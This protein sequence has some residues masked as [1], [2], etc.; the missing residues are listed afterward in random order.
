MASNPFSDP[1]AVASY[2]ERAHRMVPG[3]GVLHGI[4]DQVLAESVPQDGRIL[5]VGAGG[6]LELKHFAQHHDGWTFDGVD[7]SEPMLALA[8]V[9]MG[10][11][12][13]RASLHEGDVTI[14]PDGPFDAATC[15][16]TL[17]FLDQAERL[18]TLCAI[19]R[20]L[21][22][23]APFLTFHHS[24]PLDGAR[25]TRFER[26]ARFSAGPDTPPE[27]VSRT[28]A[29]LASQLP[30]VGPEADEG[31]L[32]EAGFRSVEVYYSALTLRGWLAYA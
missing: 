16:L 13:S 26:F 3:L 7:P 15:L 25:R 19:R 20:R 32:L 29:A 17:H 12:G 18:E 8:R 28:G 5:V 2:V 31:L 27:D 1:A 6:G 22:P 23:G 14:A 4:V 24:V 9:T 11:L 10:A 21:R 30:M